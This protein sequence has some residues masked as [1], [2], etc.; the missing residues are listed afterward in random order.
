MSRRLGLHL[1]NLPR[2]AIGKSLVAATAIFCCIMGA[3]YWAAHKRR[4]VV[5]KD[6]SPLVDF[7]VDQ[8]IATSTIALAAVMTAAL[9]LAFFGAALAAD[10]QQ[11][12][13]WGQPD[14]AAATEVQDALLAST[15]VEDALVERAVVADALVADAAVEHTDVRDA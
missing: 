11:V 14:E 13:A 8:E 12:A 6:D 9:T 10:T 1:G 15:A 7:F 5:G 3:A 4:S 2:E